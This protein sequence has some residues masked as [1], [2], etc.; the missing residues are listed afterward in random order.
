ME[1]L[2]SFYVSGDPGELEA[3]MKVL[4]EEMKA[5]MPNEFNTFC[6]TDGLLYSLCPKLVC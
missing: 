6:M 1:E 2:V 3:M 5:D 4:R